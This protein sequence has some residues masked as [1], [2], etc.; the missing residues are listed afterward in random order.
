MTVL[1]AHETLL[2]PA[3][4]STRETARRTQCQNHLK[5]MALAALNFE[6]VQTKFP[7]AAQERDGN[8]SD[9]V[10]PPLSRHNGISFLL[11]HF[12]EMAT[13]SAIDF[14]F[15]WNHPSNEIHTKQD[16]GGIL[17]CPSTPDPR[18]NGHVTDYVAAKRLDTS[19]G[20][21]KPLVDGGV[22]DHKRG[23]STDDRVWNGILQE[24]FCELTVHP[25]E[26]LLCHPQLSD[27]RVVRSAHVK[28]GLTNTWL[29]MES[30]GKPYIYGTDEALARYDV[31]WG[32]EHRSKNSRFRWAS[33]RTTITINNYCGTQ[34]IINCDNVSKPYSFHGDGSN[35]AYADGAVR[36][37]A[38]SLD[39]QVFVSL[40]TIAGREILSI[41]DL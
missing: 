16:L 39:A 21:L 23:A 35:I 36:F 33:Q 34:Q 32:E 17:I 13:F 20:N 37:H 26:G 28:D 10:E 25:T 8:V 11:A 22:I 2:L 15:D 41:D 4:Q 38:D 40:Y 27:R 7:P 9:A 6:A 31:G 1:P 3:V 19:A 18:V 12:E 29:W 14:R 30:A 24:D 5:N